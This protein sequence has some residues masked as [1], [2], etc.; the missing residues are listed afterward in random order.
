M[1]KDTNND[2][3][4]L[5][6]YPYTDAQYLIGLEDLRKVKAMRNPDNLAQQLEYG[7]V[8]ILN[9]KYQEA[10]DFFYPIYQKHY[11]DG[12]GVGQIYVSLIGLGKT[13]K[14]F[15]WIVPPRILRLNKATL[16]MCTKILSENN[17]VVYILDLFDEIFLRRS[18][19]ITFDEFEFSDFIIQNSDNFIL[20]GD[21]A[22]PLYFE[23][24][25]KQ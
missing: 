1:P 25:L 24:K 13:E 8:L 19:H 4:N 9:N 17:E 7:D 2:S 10:I 22:K 5:K 6:E 3:D 18:D 21:P 16:D 14:D 12:I 11:E 15:K 23:I 20:I